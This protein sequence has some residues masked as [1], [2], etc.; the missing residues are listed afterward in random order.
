[1]MHR[2]DAETDVILAKG[3]LSMKDANSTK[4]AKELVGEDIAD[5]VDL[6]GEDWNE[7]FSNK[8]ADA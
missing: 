4:E 2:E 7:W 8:A 5:M 1:M 6:P 3:L